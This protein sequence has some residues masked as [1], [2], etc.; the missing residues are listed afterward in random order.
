[1]LASCAMR[2]S[3]LPVI[4]Y[5]WQGRWLS[6]GH[7]WLC[8]EHVCELLLASLCHLCILLSLQVNGECYAF[9]ILKLGSEQ[10]AFDR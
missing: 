1:M 5:I 8:L 2:E 9:D 10:N 7:G 6:L 4:H 3:C